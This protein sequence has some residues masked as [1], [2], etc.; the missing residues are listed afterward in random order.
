MRKLVGYFAVLAVVLSSCNQEEVISPSGTY[1]EGQIEGVEGGE[2]ILL[3]SLM[4]NAVKTVDTIIPDPDGVFKI[5]PDVPRIGFYR[6]FVHNN[7]FVNVILQ[8]NDT[9]EFE[10]DITDLEGTYYISGSEETQKFKEL[11]DMLNAYMASMDSINNQIQISQSK[12]YLQE[13]AD[14]MTIRDQNQM[15]TGNRIR[16]FVN[17][18]S[19]YLASLSAVQKLDPEGDFELFVKVKDDL[20]PKIGGTDLH[21]NLSS[22]IAQWRKAQIGAKMLDITLK[23]PLGESITLYEQFGEYTLVDFWASWCRPCR[24]ENPNIVEAYKK[25][26]DKGFKVVGIS[27]DKEPREW[28]AAIENDRLQWTHMSDLKFWNSAAV[29]QYNIGSIPASFLVD[30]DGN[31]VAKNLRGPG[32]DLK[33]MQLFGEI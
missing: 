30:K 29:Q 5:G 8:P 20:E 10:A 23:N 16:A 25:Y 1:V 9:L 19:T 27:L 26:R 21:N 3:Q 18:N 13:V 12:Q 7:S 22:R 31:I 33:L 17:E 11:N 28:K 2:L 15:N 14:L 24:A 6:I 32:L 4:D